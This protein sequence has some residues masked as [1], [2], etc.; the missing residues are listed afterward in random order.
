MP[1]LLS[2]M[3]LL[4]ESTRLRLILLLMEEELTVAELQ[5]ILGM[6]QSRIS[7]SLA[8]LRQQGL[9]SDRRVGKNSY[10]TALTSSLKLLEKTLLAARE[11][12]FE[13][14][15]DQRALQLILEKR[16]DQAGEYFDKLAG[17]FGH[18][19]VPGRSWQGLAHGLLRLLPPLVI[20]DLGSGEGTLSQLLARSAK[21]VIAVDHLP[22][23]IDF[24][25]KIAK[26]NGFKNLEYR[27]GDIENPPIKKNSIDLALLSQTLHYT[28]TPQ[29]AL[30][31]VFRI[32]K[33]GGKILILDLA[34]HY[35]EE[36]R[37]LYG[38]IWLGFSNIQLHEMLRKS[39]FIHPEVYPVG[40][41]SAKPY[42]QTILATSI[43]PSSK[44]NTRGSQYQNNTRRSD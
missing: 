16:R 6:P 35:H 34:N 38:H 17:K 31:A 42:F 23:M 28:S 21:K 8:Q 25:K 18:S 4:S 14:S 26:Q 44:T 27:L 24:G 40:R 3:R 33:P 7:A 2:T 9:V 39:G 1:S 12:V 5:E 22:K 32:L 30:D 41:E 36:A 29:R 20:A 15:R 37:K 43:K 19:Y 10:Y 11:E 13:S